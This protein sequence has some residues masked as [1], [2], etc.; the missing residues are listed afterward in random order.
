MVAGFNYFVGKA[1]YKFL[2]RLA[3]LRLDNY[4]VDLMAENLIYKESNIDR[5]NVIRR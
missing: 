5:K 3:G 2:V 1:E 4:A